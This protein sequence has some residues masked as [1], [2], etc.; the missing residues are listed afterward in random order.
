MTER[1]K[2]IYEFGPFRLDAAEHVLLREG[3]PV[4]LVP[5]ALTTLITLVEQRGRLVKKEELMQRI[6]PDTVVEENNLN[7]YI[8]ALRKA[9]GEANDGQRY[10]E[11]VP[12]RGYRFIAEVRRLPAVEELVVEKHTL[13]RIVAESEEQATDEIGQS[14]RVAS[15]LQLK[16]HRVASLALTASTV[17]I[18]AAVCVSAIFFYGRNQKPKPEMTIERLTNGGVFHSAT[19][20]PDGKYVAYVE[21][22]SDGSH[23]LVKQTEQS[24]PIEITAPEKHYIVAATFSPDAQF[25]YFV[26]AE[27]QNAQG[28]L[29]RAPTLGGPQMKVLAGIRSPISFSPDGRQFVFTRFEGDTYHTRLVTAAADGSNQRVLATKEG[30]EFFN[31]RGG[32]WSPN[33]RQL[34]I[35]LWQQPTA[36]NPVFCS[37]V[38]VDVESGLIRPLIEQKWDNCG[39]LAWTSDGR[40]LVLVGTKRGE[41]NTVRRDQLWYVSLPDGEARRITTDLSR[42]YYDSLGISADSSSLLV[43]PFNSFSRI[44]SMDASGDAQTARQL[45]SGTNDG[46]AGFTILRDGR[47]VFVRRTGDHT[48]LWQMKADGTEQKQLT[49][50]PPFLEEVRATPDGRYLIFASN[51]DGRSHLFRVDADGTNLKQLTRGEST[52]LGSDISPDGRVLVYESHTA[53]NAGG[54]WK[55]TLEGDAPV[56][57]LEKDVYAP[58][59]SP[60]GQFIAYVRLDQDGRWKLGV[61]STESGSVIKEF[62]T[63]ND[64]Q[65][66]AGCSFTPDGQAL[67]YIV[68]Q[69]G[70]SNIWLQP[71]DG[72]APH[73]LTNFQNGSIYDYAFS[74]DGSR[75]FLSRGTDV[76]DVTLIKNFT[77]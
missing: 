76:H 44:W 21:E 68:I 40:G 49:S 34:A 69:N 41:S 37:I 19:M 57:L 67:S 18:A 74:P 28:D 39:R 12:T 72:S 51:R 7:K 47:L 8:S 38:S 14:P 2:E 6:W 31:E 43:L 73:P 61:I 33:G 1:E 20:S 62:E 59:F 10:I 48:D 27:N 4:P 70:T 30:A 15:R 63:V 46:R 42:Y 50:D 11:T 29:F 3:R 36:T 56:R 5:K 9:L 24:N 22:E 17:F 58:R 35:G 53:S 77:H 54:L 55:N 23:L 64:T 45:T 13:T 32:A 66:G 71:V 26:A 16:S 60:D 75:L 52:E 25:I 65:P